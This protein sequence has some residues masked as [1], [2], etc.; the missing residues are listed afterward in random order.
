MSLPYTAE[1]PYSD[2]KSAIRERS[3]VQEA[4]HV[5]RV[6]RRT[7]FLSVCIR[8]AIDRSE[9]AKSRWMFVA[10]ENTYERRPYSYLEELLEE[11]KR[12][13]VGTLNRSSGTLS[14][15]EQILAVTEARAKSTTEEEPSRNP[16]LHDEPWFLAE[17]S[18]G[19]SILIGESADAAFATRF[20]QILSDTATNHIARTSYPVIEHTMPS[21]SVQCPQLSMSQARFFV[22]TAMAYFTGHYHIVRESAIQGL[23]ELYVKKPETLDPLS[24]SKLFALFALGELHSSHSSSLKVDAPGL[25]FF[26][27]ASKV[28][29]FLQ[30]R[31]SVSAIEVLLLLVCYHINLEETA[32]D[33]GA[34]FV[35]LV[36][37]QTPLGLSSGQLSYST[38]YCDG[39]AIQP[40]QHALHRPLGE[41]A[42]DSTVVEFIHP[43]LRM[44]S[45]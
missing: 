3:N 20:R 29:G 7:P 14:Q 8:S 2:V 33:S 9:S 15:E 25:R 17:R 39:L 11:N 18:C 37:Q 16:V 35:L 13:R 36:H 28:Y 42:F 38:W 31:P 34:V 4:S 26:R 6:Y 45:I 10:R 19:I 5:T 40:A 21:T 30:E 12:L 1:S 32:T 44:L 24:S 43:R 23:L 22:R 41:R 27:H